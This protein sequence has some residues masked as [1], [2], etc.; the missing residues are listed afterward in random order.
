MLSNLKCFFC[1]KT[2]G[3]CK[4]LADKFAGIIGGNP[5]LKIG[6]HEVKG[7]GNTV[8]RVLLHIQDRLGDFKC[9]LV[10]LFAAENMAV[11]AESKENRGHMQTGNAEKVRIQGMNLAEFPHLLVFWA[12]SCG[13]TEVV[14]LTAALVELTEAKHPHFCEAACMPET[15]FFYKHGKGT[16]PEIYKIKVNR[17]FFRRKGNFF[18]QRMINMYH[19]NMQD[20]E[21][22]K[23][24]EEE[25]FLENRGK[26]LE[27]RDKTRRSEK[28]TRISDERIE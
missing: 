27:I 16:H 2:F 6:D 21:F 7:G 25:K 13:K 17:N 8:D 20:V 19:W 22:L 11:K 14:N 5:F 9:A 1:R 4:K 26:A 12:V 10:K 23:V 3:I 15:K 18:V 28:H 24:L